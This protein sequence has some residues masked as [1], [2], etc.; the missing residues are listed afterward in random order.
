[1]KFAMEHQN[2]L[3]TGM[4]TGNKSVNAPPSFSLV[5]VSNPDV[6]LWSI[7]PSEEGITNG[8]IIRLWNVK[9]D[10]G[11]ASVKLYMPVSSAWQTTHIETNKKAL[12]PNVNS[13][14]TVFTP[15]QI[16]TYRLGIFKR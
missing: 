5:N 14:Q 11:Q 16:N 4:V 6:L 9:N 8:L 12:K 1:M 7:K 10:G 13:I 2:V 15:Q 3:T